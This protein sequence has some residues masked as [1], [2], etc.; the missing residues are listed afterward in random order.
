[1]EQADKDRVCLNHE[2]L[3]RGELDAAIEIFDEEC[4]NHGMKVGR[5]GIRIVLEDIYT[6][7]PDWQ[8]EILDVVAENDSVV[9]R[10]NIR[11]THLGVGQLPV[12]GGMLRGVEPT[13]KTFEVQHIHWYKLRDGKIIEHYANRD[14]ISM[15]QQLGLL[16]QTLPSKAAEIKQESWDDA[17]DAV[18]A[19]PENHQ[20]LLENERVRV[21]SS[22]VLPGATVPLHTHKYPSVVYVLENGDFVRYD[23]E[24]NEASSSHQLPAEVK[25]Q[26]VMWLPPL[27]PHS[28][29]NIS[30]KEIRVINF[31]LKD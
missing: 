31:E 8:F 26:T 6:T 16:P 3:N 4:S 10:T 11:G 15:M 14:D 23:A 7:F 24:G 28:V 1:M 29:K 20:V 25:N 27:A 5:E 18:V 21:L 22:N 19:A 9:V 17:L 30:D 12:N 2:K 13:G